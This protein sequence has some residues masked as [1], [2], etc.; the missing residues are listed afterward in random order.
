MFD[1]SC[2][3]C[4]QKALTHMQESKTA[5]TVNNLISTLRANAKSVP[6]KYAKGINTLINIFYN[7]N[8]Y[9]SQLSPT[10]SDPAAFASTA[11]HYNLAYWCTN[12][13]SLLGLSTFNAKH[14]EGLMQC[15]SIIKALAPL[16]SLGDITN[17]FTKDNCTGIDTG[18]RLFNFQLKYNTIATKIQT[19]ITAV[20]PTTTFDYSPAITQMGTLINDINTACTQTPPLKRDQKE[21]LNALSTYVDGVTKVL[22]KTPDSNPI[23]TIQDLVDKQTAVKLV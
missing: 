15:Q 6:S 4:I 19:L 18:K 10:F 2:N 16:N 9:F 17:I 7:Y 22:P 12:K 23:T 1:G 14:V 3:P 21:A 11:G 5:D 13:E 8:L 20:A